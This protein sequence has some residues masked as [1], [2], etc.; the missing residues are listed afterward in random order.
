MKISISFISLLFFLL[1]TS[2]ENGAIK[3]VFL[4]S[5]VEEGFIGKDV[6]HK[7]QPQEE[8]EGHYVIPLVSQ[9]WLGAQSSPSKENKTS[10]L[11]FEVGPLVK[12]ARPNLTR[13]CREPPEP[14]HPSEPALSPAPLSPSHR[15]HSI[16]VT[17]I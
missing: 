5:Q 17:A 3:G 1:F 13:R 16:R 8:V 10:Y 15:S 11:P 14:S 2:E 12:L 6:V 9:G 4:V 7:G